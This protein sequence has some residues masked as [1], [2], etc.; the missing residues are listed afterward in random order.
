MYESSRANITQNMLQSLSSS[1]VW[2]FSQE[3]MEGEGK[4]GMS[5]SSALFQGAVSVHS[6]YTQI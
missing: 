3:S 2:N 5:V 6:V 4:E 1:Y